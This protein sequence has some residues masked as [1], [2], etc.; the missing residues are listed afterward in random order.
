MWVMVIGVI[1][2]LRTVVGNTSVT[3]GGRRC[4]DSVVVLLRLLLIWCVCLLLASIVRIVVLAVSH[5]F[6]EG[7]EGETIG[8][9]EKEV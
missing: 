3:N 6:D 5:D 7:E 9:E 4:I 8:E 1:E 2:W